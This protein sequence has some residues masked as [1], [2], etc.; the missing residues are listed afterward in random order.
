MI[1]SLTGARI[2]PSALAVSLNAYRLAANP[3]GSQWRKYSN[4]K[5]A[6]PISVCVHPFE[7]SGEFTPTPTRDI[8]PG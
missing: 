4:I 1:E 2:S 6:M 3:S 8:G 5:N 7:T